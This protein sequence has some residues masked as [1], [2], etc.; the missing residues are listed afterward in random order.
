M[1]L[2]CERESGGEGLFEF[3]YLKRTEGDDQAEG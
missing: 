3:N 2:I 1:L